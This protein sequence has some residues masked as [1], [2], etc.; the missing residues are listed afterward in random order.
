MEKLPVPQTRQLTNLTIETLLLD[1][2]YDPNNFK[3]SKWSLNASAQWWRLKG[4]KT[5][6]RSKLPHI[7]ATYEDLV[8]FLTK[9]LTFYVSYAHNMETKLQE[10]KNSGNTANPK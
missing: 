6:L 5:W 2:I 4:T 8:D 1:S 7:D 9:E 10:A 3:P